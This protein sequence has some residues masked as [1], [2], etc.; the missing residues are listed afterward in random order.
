[1][2]AVKRVSYCRWGLRVHTAANAGAVT[3]SMPVRARSVKWQQCFAIASIPAS[4]MRRRLQCSI[5]VG[6]EEIYG[7]VLVIASQLQL[8]H[9]SYSSQNNTWTCSPAHVQ[10]LQ[11]G[12]TV[13]HDGRNA[14]VRHQLRAIQHDDAQRA[15]MPQATKRIICDERAPHQL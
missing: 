9:H 1:M 5:R 15:Q 3:P 7:K 11:V 13:L 10:C 6:G 12:A 4:V 2:S 14:L 8:S